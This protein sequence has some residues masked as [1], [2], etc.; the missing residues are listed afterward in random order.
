M[1]FQAAVTAIAEIY[2]ARGRPL[3]WLEGV[4]NDVPVSLSAET[5]GPGDDLQLRFQ[6]GTLAEAQIRRGVD[7]GERLWKPLMHLSAAI[8]QRVTAYGVLVICPDSSRTIGRK[9][10]RDI[11]RLADGRDDGLTAIG[12]TFL[13]KLREG[14]LEFKSVCER[15]RIVTVHSLNAH[16]ASIRAARAE[17]DHLC[18]DKSQISQAWNRIYQDAHELIEFRGQRS[19]SSVLRI[20]RSDGIHLA[21]GLQDTPTSI[22]DRLI[23][24][25]LSANETFSIL[26]VAQPLPIDKAWIPIKATVQ[27]ETGETASLAEALRYYHDWNNRRRSGEGTVVD[28]ETL[29]QF[30]RHVVVVAGP[31]MGKTTLLRKL[32]HTYAGAGYP[33]L[34]VSLSAVA[35]RMR[36]SGGSF[37]ESALELGLDGSGISRQVAQ[38][39]EFDDWILLCDGLDDCGPDQEKIAR[40]LLNFAAGHPQCRIIVTTRPIGYHS[41]LLRAWRHY[42]IEPLDSTTAVTHV[43]KLLQN[44]V[45]GDTYVHREASKLAQFALREIHERELIGRGPL[46]LGMA[47]LLIARGRALGRT[48]SQL[49]S[50]LFQLIDSI[51][52]ERM[53]A[54]PPSDAVLRRFLDIIAWHLISSPTISFQSLLGRCGDQIAQ[55]LSITPLQGRELSERSVNYWQ[56]IGLLER[57]QHGEDETITFIHKTF[58][59]FAAA[60]YLC[61]L[62]SRQADVLQ[63]IA[64][65]DEW[66]EVINFAGSLGLGTPICEILLARDAPGTKR[67]TMTERALKLVSE[68]DRLPALAVCEELLQRGFEY[69]RSERREWAYRIGTVLI[70]LS[71]RLG[72]E[73][74]PIAA[75]LCDNSQHWTRLIGWACILASGSSNYQLGRLLEE[76]ARL[77]EVGTKAR[78]SLSGAYVLGIN[79]SDVI[80]NFVI[81]ATT[82][83]LERCSADVADAIIPPVLDSESLFTLGFYEKIGPILE[84]KAKRYKLRYFSW[85]NERAN[86]LFNPGPWDKAWKNSLISI[87]SA[88]DDAALQG[89]SSNL[90]QQKPFLHLRAFATA[91]NWF[92]TPTS[93]VWAWRKG[94]DVP[95]VQE[96]MRGIVA[97]IPIAR[98]LLVRDV[99]IFLSAAL[100]NEDKEWRVFDYFAHV[101]VPSP[102]WPKAKELEL[103]CSK[104][105]GAL[106]HKSVWVLPLAVNLLEQTVDSQ[107]LLP[108]L[109]RLFTTGRGYTLWAVTGLLT[110]LDPS[111]AIRLVAE[112]LSRPLVEGCEHLFAFLTS[113][114]VSLESISISV[115]RNGLLAGTAPVALAAAKLAFELAEPGNY[116]LRALVKEAYDHWVTNEEPYPTGGGTIPESPREQIV[117]TILKIG[118]DDDRQVLSYANDVRYDVRKVGTAALLERLTQSDSARDL[119]VEAAVAGTIS[120]V[121]VREGLFA[122]VPFSTTQIQRLSGLLAS[123]DPKMRYAA[124]GILDE[125]YLS[126]EKIE[127]LAKA[128]L[129]DPEP[130][131][132]DAAFKLLDGLR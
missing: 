69:V 66:L 108:I 27:P 20:L 85:F 45:P 13:S 50:R 83:I 44:I 80:E 102:D 77:P 123:G 120:V 131:I 71:E 132:R 70:S 21:S 53:I 59:E 11:R 97:I 93:D 33:V 51:P 124:L 32:A 30:F 18:Q 9:L 17:L 39:A 8:Q 28:A 34:R 109:D 2:L 88:I 103:D 98:D 40:A 112:R 106:Y 6:D 64:E 117:L 90:D 43:V 129:A 81:L 94:Y 41:P 31:G 100:E 104:L 101:D 130:E 22:L 3:G 78:A 42:A 95:A 55:E 125:T 86:Q 96:V 115:L 38:N 127:V 46:L 24:W 75:T 111:V 67:F 63:S 54:Q 82:A 1:N 116:E 113:R 4:V 68:A 87:F 89:S 65:K 35:I 19:V 107:A 48:K 121:L 29:G 62:P 57:I 52:N 7:V 5:G 74:A 79:R 119:F 122:K 110:S 91:T 12:R 114:S 72:A 61:A 25:T 26:K 76:F 105:E 60:R 37:T 92:Q 118:A 10:S 47:A 56:D 23:R 73:I 58:G 126:K 16:Q 15:L 84:S 36:H 14:G 99:R 128:K 49:Y